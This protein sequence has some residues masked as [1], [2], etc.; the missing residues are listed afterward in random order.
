[1]L[2]ASKYEEMYAPEVSAVKIVVDERVE[3]FNW[4]S[5]FHVFQTEQET[6]SVEI[7]IIFS[8]FNLSR[9]DQTRFCS[10]LVVLFS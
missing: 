2:I 5:S 10:I 8:V 1:M 7:E 9:T 4:Q 6:L 3:S